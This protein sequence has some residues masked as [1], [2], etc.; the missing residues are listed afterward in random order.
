MP[1]LDRQ[2]LQEEFNMTNEI[3]IIEPEVVNDGIDEFEL[4]WEKDST[5]ISTLRTNIDKANDNEL[6]ERASGT[7]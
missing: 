5:D 4:E 1:T 2:G 7:K 6:Q 3:E